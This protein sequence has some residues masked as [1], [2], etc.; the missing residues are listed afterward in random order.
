MTVQQSDTAAI[1]FF[2]AVGVAVAYGMLAL[3]IWLAPVDLS[4]KGYWGLGIL[5]LTLALVNFVKYRF[6]TKIAE[7]RLARL[8]D[9]KNEKLMA[10]YIGEK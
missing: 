7:D 10:D 9:A 1:M 4:T 2:N 6:D 5:L 8:E 3:S